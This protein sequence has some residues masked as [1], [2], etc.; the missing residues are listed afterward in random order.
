MYFTIVRHC[1]SYSF[2][3]FSMNKTQGL[4]FNVEFRPGTVALTFSYDSSQGIKCIFP[5]A[6][7]LNVISFCIHVQTNS[8]IN[9]NVQ[10]N[11]IQNGNQKKFLGL[12]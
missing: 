7:G 10:V 9:T 11:N 1:H 4:D 5:L 12:M 2:Q 3:I 6:F 8:V